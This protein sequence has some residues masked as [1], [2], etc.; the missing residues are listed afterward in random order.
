METF[1]RETIQQYLLNPWYVT[2]FVDGEGTFTFSRSGNHMTLCFGLKL[3]AQDRSALELIREFFKGIGQIYHVKAYSSHKGKTKA[4]AYFRVTRINDL[5]KIVDHFDNY[6]LKSTKNKQFKIWREMVMI[7][8]NN[9]RRKHLDEL[10]ILAKK[11]SALSP[12]NQ[13]WHD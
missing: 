5:L 3:T 12:R 1:L 6:P 8:Y 13:V 4:A 9:F 7:K 11:L 10:E 2:G